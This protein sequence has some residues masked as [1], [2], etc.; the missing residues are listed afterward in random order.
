MNNIKITVE[1]ETPK[2]D[3]FNELFEQYKTIKSAADDSVSY[4][5]PLADA[6]EESKLTC[7]LEQLFVISEYLKTLYE[8]DNYNNKIVVYAF[9]KIKPGYGRGEFSMTI[10]KNKRIHIYWYSHPFTLE[11]YKVNKWAF[12][13]GEEMNILG[14]WNKWKMFE[15]LENASVNKLT[16]EMEKQHKR[17]EEQKNRLD[18]IV[19]D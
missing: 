16:S 18:N 17:V 8:I 11:Y 9:D 15:K 1:Y 5:K 12:T 7:I 3:R 19:N 4:Y 10:D 2:T 13:R 6:A 14:N